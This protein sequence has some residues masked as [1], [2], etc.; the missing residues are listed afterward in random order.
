MKKLL[1]LSLLSLFSFI[2][3][4]E[5]T[6]DIYWLAQPPAVRELRF[7]PDNGTERYTKAE[8]LAKEGFKIDVPIMVFGWDAVKVMKLRHDYGYTW[9]PSA[10]MP[11]ITIAPGLVMHGSA[12]YDPNAPPS[13]AIKVSTEAKDFPPFEKPV[14]VEQK[15]SE[16]P[17]GL[18]SLGSIYLTVAGDKFPDGTIVNEPRGKFIKK[19]KVSPFGAWAYW[20]KL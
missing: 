1:V 3:A 7:L 4:Q 20:E 2:G 8:S 6:N 12:P 16:S 9:V 18:Q 13:G 11:N 19:V 5:L 17:V 15:V 10:L 14:P